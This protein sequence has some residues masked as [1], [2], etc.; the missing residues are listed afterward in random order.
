LQK[1][2]GNLLGPLRGKR[3]FTTPKIKNIG[4]WL[5][6][7]TV[8]FSV[9]IYNHVTRQNDIEK[10]ADAGV[11]RKVHLTSDAMIF[12]CNRQCLCKCNVWRA[13]LHSMNWTRGFMNAFQHRAKCIHLSGFAPLYHVHHVTL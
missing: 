11:W 8:V 12:R 10:H 5:G 7:N 6:C 13:C 1:I 3:L 2:R 4:S 9:N